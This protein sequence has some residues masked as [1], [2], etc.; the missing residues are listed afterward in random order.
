[1]NILTL[2]NV[3]IYEI[4]DYMMNVIIYLSSYSPYSNPSMVSRPDDVHTP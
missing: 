1:M 2:K 3:T 4:N